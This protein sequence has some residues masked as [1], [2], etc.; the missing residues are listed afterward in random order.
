MFPVRLAMEIYGAIGLFGLVLAAVGLAGVTAYSVTRRSREIGIRVAL[1]AGRGDVLRL[2]MGEGAVLV[3]AGTVLGLAGAWSAARRER[4]Q[5]LRPGPAGG[6]PA[7]AGRPGA[8]GVLPA[9]AQI[10][11]HRCGGG[12]APEMAAP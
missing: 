2:A 10:H 7:A 8:G 11:A 3:A 12:V 5:H 6:R 1:G 9:G 4:R